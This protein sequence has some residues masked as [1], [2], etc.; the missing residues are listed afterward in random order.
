MLKLIYIAHPFGCEQENVADAA[1]TCSRDCDLEIFALQ[2]ALTE[3]DRR[4][5]DEFLEKQHD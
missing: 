5:R 4:A 3:L 2:Q 1:R